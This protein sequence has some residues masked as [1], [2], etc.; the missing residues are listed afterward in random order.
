MQIS[1]CV[2]LYMCGYVSVAVCM[3]LCMFFLN[4]ALAPSTQL[5]IFCGVCDPSPKSEIEHDDVIKWKHFPHNWP[6]VRGIHRSPVKNSPHKGRW[7]RAL[8]FSW[9]CVWKKKTLSKQPWGWWFETPSHPLWRHCNEKKFLFVH[10]SSISAVKY[11][12]LAMALITFSYTID[13][14]Y[15]API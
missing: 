9:I 6:F 8:M 11:I 13:V 15:L 10:L 12:Q 2:H 7:C 14:E 3:C 1:S 5:H 4:F